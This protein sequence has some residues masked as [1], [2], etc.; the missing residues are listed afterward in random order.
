MPFKIVTKIVTKLNTLCEH[1][2]HSTII[3]G[4]GGEV[5][6]MCSQPYPAIPINIRVVKCNDFDDRG[7]VSQ[8]EYEDIG[9]VLRTD[10]R[11]GK[12]GFEPPKK[13]EE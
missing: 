8:R 3:G 11:T 13:Q 7:S 1:C 5:I 9:W 12:V 6:I 10:K 4:A 2:R